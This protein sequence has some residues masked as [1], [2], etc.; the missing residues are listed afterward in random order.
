[1]LR[2]CELFAVFLILLSLSIDHTYGQNNPSSARSYLDDI[3]ESGGALDQEP[4]TDRSASFFSAFLPNQQ[5]VLNPNYN[6]KRPAVRIR[7]LQSVHF[8]AGPSL[9]KRTSS[10]K[11]TLI[12]TQQQTST[13]EQGRLIISNLP[14]GSEFLLASGED[15]T[16]KPMLHRVIVPTAIDEEDTPMISLEQITTE[17]FNSWLEAVGIKE[18]NNRGHI[19]GKVSWQSHQNTNKTFRKNF[20]VSIFQSSVQ[21]IYFDANGQVNL[22]LKA[23]SSSGK[24][25][26]F[27]HPAESVLLSVAFNDVSAPLRTLSAVFAGYTTS[28]DIINVAEPS[29]YDITYLHGGSATDLTLHVPQPQF[30]HTQPQPSTRPLHVIEGQIKHNRAQPQTGTKVSQLRDANSVSLSL[31]TA[32]R[33][34]TVSTTNPLWESALSTIPPMD[35][36]DHH[37]LLVFPKSTFSELA[38]MIGAGFIENLSSLIITHGLKPQEKNISVISELWDERGLVKKH[39]WL[40]VHDNDVLHAAFFNLYPGRYQWLLKSENGYWLDSRVVDILERIHHSVQSG[41]QYILTEK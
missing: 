19:C 31:H 41:R 29:P 14:P 15:I 3:F 7:F 6:N 5:F 22:D 18:E 1:M 12:G 28:I 8:D 17:H 37:F 13:D 11:V 26:F 39:D 10:L 40:R 30:L 16:Y 34:P 32:A 27:N 38:H 35:A 23:T 2:S 25:C 36:T 24:F 20:K 33:R 9:Q 21:P 4:I